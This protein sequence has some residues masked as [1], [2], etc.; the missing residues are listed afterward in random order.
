MHRP[1][2]RRLG[3]L[4][5]IVVLGLA[6]FTACGD[7]D[8]DSGSGSGSGSKTDTSSSK[9]DTIPTYTEDDTDITVALEHAFVIELPV[10]SGTGYAWTAESNPKLQQMTT[11]QVAGGSQPGAQATQKITFRSQGTGTTTLVLDYARSFEPDQPPAK[12]ASF[13]VT[14]TD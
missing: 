13:D 4:F 11:E 6:V 8:S 14:I 7:A 1:R 2:T 3:A 5:V 12:T 9:S 10:T